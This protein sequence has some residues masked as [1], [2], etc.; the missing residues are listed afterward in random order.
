MTRGR[1]G[2]TNAVID[3][4]CADVV[5]LVAMTRQ[6]VI[7]TAKVFAITGDTAQV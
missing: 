1:D 4:L 3:N 5:L 6:H 7:L 2:R